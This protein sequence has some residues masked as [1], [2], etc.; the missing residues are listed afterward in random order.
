MLQKLYKS[1]NF[2]AFPASKIE[3]LQKKT[4]CTRKMIQL[5]ILEHLGFQLSECR[6]CIISIVSCYCCKA[7]AYNIPALRGVIASKRAMSSI[8]SSLL[9]S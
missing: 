1:D 6:I 9:I 5:P 4:I 7:F 2:F 3:Q 8:L